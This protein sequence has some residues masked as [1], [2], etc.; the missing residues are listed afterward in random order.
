V[1]SYTRDSSEEQINRRLAT[2]QSDG[3]GGGREDGIEDKKL[4]R[5][6]GK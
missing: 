5:K 4:T 6:Q 3:G 2:H 1:D